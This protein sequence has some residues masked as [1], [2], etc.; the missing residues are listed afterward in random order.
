MTRWKSAGLKENSEE[1]FTAVH[2]TGQT[3]DKCPRVTG[4]REVARIVLRTLK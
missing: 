1:P 3:V 2:R 4:V